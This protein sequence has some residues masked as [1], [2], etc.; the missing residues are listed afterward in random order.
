MKTKPALPAIERRFHVGKVELREA[1]AGTGSPAAIRG[2]A[3]KFNANSENLGG[4]VE[5]IAPGAFDDVLGDDVRALFNHDANLI[6]GRTKSGTCKIG[7]DAVGLWYEI[8]PADNT[9]SRDLMVSLKRGDVDQS[10]FAFA[11]TREGQEWKDA[12]GQLIR[13]IRK[14]FKLYDVSPVTYPAYPD[15]EA[16]ARTLESARALDLVPPPAPVAPDPAIAIAAA[17]R[18][19]ALQLARASV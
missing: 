3:A 8:T 11:V 2:Y 17:Q 6:L 10:S 13:T 1:D 12:E 14:V 19:R 5:I 18:E 4:F 9:A 7:V 16:A 15:T